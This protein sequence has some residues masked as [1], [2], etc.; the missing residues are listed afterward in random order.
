MGNIVLVKFGN[1]YFIVGVLGIY[2]NLKLLWNNQ[3]FKVITMLL[4]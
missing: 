4:L 1:Y 3:Y 2:I